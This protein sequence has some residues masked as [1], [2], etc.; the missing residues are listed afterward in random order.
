MPAAGAAA[1][2]GRS[3]GS[4]PLADDL[5]RRTRARRRRSPATHQPPAV[6]ALAHAIN[7]KLG[8]V[9]KTVVVTGLDRAAGGRG[10]RGHGRASFKALVDEMNAGQGRGAAHPRR[11]PGRTP[12]RPTSTSPRR[13]TKVAK[14][15]SSTSACTRTRRRRSATGTSTPPTTSKPGATSA[16]TTARSRIQQPL[17]APLYGGKSPIELLAD[18]STRAGPTGRRDDRRRRWSSSR[19]RWRKHFDGDGR[20]PAT[21]TPWWQTAVRDGRRPGHAPPPAGRRARHAELADDRAF[22]GPAGRQAAARST[23]AP[24]RRIYD[25]RF[26]NNGWLQELPKPITKLTWDNAAIVSPK[27]AGG[28]RASTIELRGW[29]GGEHGRAEADVV[30]L[31]LDGR[32]AR[33][34]AV[35]DLPGHADDVRHRPPRLRPRA[36]AGQGRQPATGFNAYALR[37]TDGR[38]GRAGGLT[39]RDDRRATYFLACTQGQYAMESRRPVRARPPAR[40]F[41]QNH[42]FAQIPPASAAEYQ[43]LAGADPRHA[44]RTASGC[45][46]A[47]QVAARTTTATTHG[48]GRPRTTSTAARQAAHPA[49][50]VPR[51]PAAGDRRQE[52]SERTAGGR[53]RSTW[54]PAPGARPASSPAWPRTTSRSS[55]RTQVTRGREMHWIRIDRYF[56]IPGTRPATTVEDAAA[57]R[58]ERRSGRRHP[59]ALPAGACASSARRPRAR[60][61]ARSGR[62]STRADGLNDMVYN[63]CVGTRYC[64]NNCPYK[65]RRFNFLQFADSTTDSLKL[66]QQPG[67]DGPPARA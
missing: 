29:T 12:P 58:A 42:D 15:T 60:S 51:Q 54:R 10:R 33:R 23:S 55:A 19:R 31:T 3:S 43:E 64:S 65:V 46:E 36:R 39:V 48:E 27:T 6:H 45:T 47:P 25:G 2:A 17:I 44:R 30:E 41:K 38:C 50:P 21:S 66:V 57:S 16:G 13:S 61:S 11:Q 67:R 9:G 56:T 14:R 22:A 20:S 26:A 62:R 35:L 49:D 24:T 8:G 63:R 1:G 5:Q 7:E 53:W 4:T 18:C 32:D 28:A 34:R 40:Q 37:T 59:D 52:A